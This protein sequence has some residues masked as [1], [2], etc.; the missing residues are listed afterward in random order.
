MIIN[1]SWK[2]FFGWDCFPQIWNGSRWKLKI[3]KTTFVLEFLC[4][5]INESGEMYR[6][7]IVY[8]RH[9]KQHRSCRESLSRHSWHRYELFTTICWKS[10][11]AMNMKTNSW[12]KRK[13]YILFSKVPPF[14]LL[15]LGVHSKLLFLCST[16]ARRGPYF[17][18]RKNRRFALFRTNEVIIMFSQLQNCLIALS[19]P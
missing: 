16:R 10:Y 15:R 9:T 8:L 19:K 7:M 13:K 4:P 11:D 1:R 6:D 2:W 5:Y 14:F 3:W 17:V 12:S 18:C